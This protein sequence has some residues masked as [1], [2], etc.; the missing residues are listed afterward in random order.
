[1]FNL[2]Q[3]AWIHRYEGCG[4]ALQKLLPEDVLNFTN[5]VVFVSD[6][7]EKVSIMLFCCMC[8]VGLIL[9]YTILVSFVAVINVMCC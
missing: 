3:S 5:A 8:L 7:R 9:K 4:E 6:S 1:M 2:F